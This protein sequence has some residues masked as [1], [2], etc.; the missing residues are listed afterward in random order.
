MEIGQWKKIETPVGAVRML[1]ADRALV[2]TFLRHVRPGDSLFVF[3]YQATVY[4]LTLGKNPTHFSYLQPGLMTDDDELTALNEL[5]AHPPR[6][7][8]YSD[9]PPEL[10]LKHWPSSDPKR[11]RM[12]KIEAFLKERYRSV[13]TARRHALGDFVLLERKD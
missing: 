6:W 3:P 11:L 5:N 1:P 9:V 13:E 2:E 4:F 7:V 8:W 12:H 10:Y